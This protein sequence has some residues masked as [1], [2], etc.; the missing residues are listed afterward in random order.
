MYSALS[1]SLSLSVS[2]QYV[3]QHTHRLSCPSALSPISFVRH[4]IF[5]FWWEGWAQNLHSLNSF[6]F[7]F[8]N[9]SI[10]YFFRLIGFD[11]FWLVRHLNLVDFS[12]VVWRFVT[13]NRDTNCSGVFFVSFGRHF[14]NLVFFKVQ[15]SQPW[16]KNSSSLFNL[17]S[18]PPCPF[19]PLL[20]LFCSTLT[21]V[22]D[23][24]PPLIGLFD[25]RLTLDRVSTI[26]CVC[27]CLNTRSC[28]TLAPFRPHSQWPHTKWPIVCV[29]RRSCSPW[30]APLRHPPPSPYTPTLSPPKRFTLVLMLMMLMVNMWTGWASYCAVDSSFLGQQTFSKFKLVRF[31]LYSKLM[32]WKL[33]SIRYLFHSRPNKKVF[34]SISSA[35]WKLV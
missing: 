18:F 20:L 11:R 30:P 5:P 25:L 6:V 23:C 4:W 3:S 27:V 1:L 16:I 35:S 33:N 7:F 12:R 17:L 8:G 29:R 19:P 22:F 24:K 13:K 14:P 28:F 26:V 32:N 9:R 2:K 31:F 10:D 21:C 34:S 15:G